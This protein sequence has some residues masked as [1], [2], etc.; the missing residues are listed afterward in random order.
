MSSAA[1]HAT[2]AQN[3]QKMKRMAAFEEA[4]LHHFVR[5]YFLLISPAPRC[6]AHIMCTVPSS[7]SSMHSACDVGDSL[8]T[9]PWRSDGICE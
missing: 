6:T 1:L 5:P 7:G 8:S 2:L 4:S 3:A 9:H